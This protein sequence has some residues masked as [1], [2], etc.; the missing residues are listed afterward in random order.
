MNRTK[1]WLY[2]IAAA[3]LLLWP[4]IS[5]SQ[6]S[7]TNVVLRNGYYFNSTTGERCDADGNIWCGAPPGVQVVAPGGERI[8]MIRLP[9]TCASVCFGGRRRNRL[10]MTASQSLYALYVE[11]TGAHEDVVGSGHREIDG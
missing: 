11:T 4:S 10:F 1:Q 7:G 5:H 2:L 6:T 3:S 9:E 8:G